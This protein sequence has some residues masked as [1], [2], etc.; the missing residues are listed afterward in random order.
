M[1]KHHSL[2]VVREHTK[3]NT[4][5]I[6]HQRIPEFFRVEGWGGERSDVENE[7]ALEMMLIAE[8]G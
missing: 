5:G 6:H 3:V 1:E 8:P 2:P 7:N 4:P